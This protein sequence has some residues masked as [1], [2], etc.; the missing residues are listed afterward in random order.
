MLRALAVLLLISLT[1]PAWAA[2]SHNGT[3]TGACAASAASITFS[4]TVAAGTDVVLIV[5][6]SGIGAPVNNVSGVTFN[7]DA[8]GPVTGAAV[9]LDDTAD[10][11][12]EQWFLGPG[13]DADGM[14]HNVIVTYSGANTAVCAGAVALDGV[15]QGATPYRTPATQTGTSG[16][17]PT[18]SVTSVSGDWVIDAIACNF[19]SCATLEG[20]GQTER[21]SAVSG[22][23]LNVDMSSETATT[24]ST[25]MTYTIT[26]TDWWA[27]VGAAFI[28]AAG[29]VPPTFI[30]L[31][32]TQ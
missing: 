32:G 8:L 29:A 4:R 20:A 9:T 17:T 10:I 31:N 15:N 16:T 2:I 28:P 3:S 6:A 27:Y 1:S 30:Q 24:T 18:L 21:V 26:N 11:R 7:G 12:S 23:T 22:T 25:A 13:V 5:G 19:N 14:A